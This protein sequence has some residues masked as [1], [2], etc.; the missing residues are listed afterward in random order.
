MI[1]N[2]KTNNSNDPISRNRTR[3]IFKQLVSSLKQVFFI[4]NITI[5][6]ISD[7]NFFGHTAKLSWKYLIL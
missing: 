7:S 6:E 5:L 2:R 4:A 1:R 3:N